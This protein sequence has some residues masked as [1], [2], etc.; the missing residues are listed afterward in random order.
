MTPAVFAQLTDAQIWSIYFRERDKE[1][2]LHRR[3]RKDREAPITGETLQIPDEA[4]AL[5]PIEDTSYLSLFWSVWR[6]RR[7]KSAEETFAKWKE[8]IASETKRGEF[9]PAYTHTASTEGVVK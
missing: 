5:W 8:Y 9:R 7:K 4:Y 1:G 2:K 6:I 3:Y